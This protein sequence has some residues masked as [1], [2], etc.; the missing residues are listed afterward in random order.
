[1][2]TF[3][4]V[5][6][7]VRGKM[8]NLSDCTDDELKDMLVLLRKVRT[9]VPDSPVRRRKK[10]STD[11]LAQKV[12]EVAKKL[13]KPAEEVMEMLMGDETLKEAMAVEEENDD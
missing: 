6:H 8:K 11:F 4:E 5:I 3:E 9:D 1:M 13:G 2:A 7:N 10:K 12:E